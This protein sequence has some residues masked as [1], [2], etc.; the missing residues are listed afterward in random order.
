MSSKQRTDPDRKKVLNEQFKKYTALQKE[1][2]KPTFE[3]HMEKFTSLSED[4]LTTF[5]PI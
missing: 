4:E 1:V 5:R 2:K 3:K